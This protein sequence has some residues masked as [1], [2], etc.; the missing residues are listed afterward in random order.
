LPTWIPDFCLCR[1]LGFFVS[2]I[3]G[4][5]SR[6]SWLMLCLWNSASSWFWN[7]K[8]GCRHL[9][10]SPAYPASVVDEDNSRNKTRKR[11]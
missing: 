4:P 8:P 11:T 9:T 3:P 7:E 6:I 1:S 5:S 10:S 2:L